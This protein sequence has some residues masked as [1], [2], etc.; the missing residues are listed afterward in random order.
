VVRSPTARAGGVNSN[1][2][3]SLVAL[4]VRAEASE[5]DLLWVVLFDIDRFLRRGRPNG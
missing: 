4:A 1:T 5:L 2:G 3:S